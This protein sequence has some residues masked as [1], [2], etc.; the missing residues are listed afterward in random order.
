MYIYLTGGTKKYSFVKTNEAKTDLTV[1]RLAG[2]ST[3][4]LH[5][6]LLE[7]TQKDSLSTADC[8]LISFKL[9]AVLLRSSVSIR[10]RAPGLTDTLRGL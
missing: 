7:I 10:K 5:I 3:K 6:T 8:R 2:F 9:L 4:G 1:I